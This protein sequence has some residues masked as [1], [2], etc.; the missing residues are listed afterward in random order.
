[1]T[2]RLLI[3][4]DDLAVGATIA[5][6]AEA[7][8][9]VARVT[10]SPADFF[11]LVES[12][13][14][15]HIAVDLVMPEM[16]GVQ[17]MVELGSRRCMAGIIVTS[18]VGQ[19]V[20]E[21]AGRSAQE[22]GLNIIGVLHKPFSPQTLRA[23][24]WV[25]T[26]VLTDHSGTPQLAKAPAMIASAGFT[27]TEDQLRQAFARR[28]L[29]V[30][31]QPKI[32]C[33]TGALAGFEALVRWIHPEKGIIMPDQFVVFAEMHGM[34]DELTEQVFDGALT[35]FANN[36]SRAKVNL[37][38]NLSAVTISNLA[39]SM[40]ISAKTLRD[41][42]FVERMLSNCHDKGVSPQRMI[43]ELTETSAM[44]NP[45]ASLDLL[46]RLRMKGFQLSIDDFGTG[47]SS[48]LQLVRLPFSEIKVDKSFVM[49]ALRSSES[50]AVVKSIIDLGHSLGIKA[51]AEGV[52]NEP[53]LNYLRDI[54]CDFAQGYFI[55][56]PMDGDAV[57]RWIE[58][59]FHG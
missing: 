34:I 42:Q 33:D 19:R 45:T 9:V 1:M 31:F 22:H 52:E 26:L 18:G 29:G 20:L 40:N 13:S 38:V 59:R 44:E 49:T 50:Q 37:S 24:L 17:V 35:W 2:S 39:L 46:T 10:S 28:E 47:Y 41:Q 6:I 56:R 53:T 43:F 7:S 54:G 25:P 23:L 57:L 11:Q 48:M 32:D 55:G 8:G 3:L 14:P 27:V 58:G 15:T 16:D 5:S 51:T 21:A 30:Y 36:F 4:D 12:F